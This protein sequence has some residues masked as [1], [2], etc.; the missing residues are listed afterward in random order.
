MATKHLLEVKLF[1]LSLNGKRKEEEARKKN[2]KKFF[3]SH[4][5]SFSGG[6][7]FSFWRFSGGVVFEQVLHCLF[8]LLHF[9]V[10]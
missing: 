7:V 8:E 3:F 9:L 10:N 2:S 4:F 6:V 5:L 1:Y